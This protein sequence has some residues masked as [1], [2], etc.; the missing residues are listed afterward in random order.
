MHLSTEQHELLECYKQMLLSWNAIH[1]LSGAKDSQSIQKNIDNSLFPLK[2]IDLSQKHLI[3]DIGSGNGFPA[4]PLHIALRIPTILCEPN[5]KK[6]AFLQNIKATLGLQNLSIQRKKIESLKLE[7]LPDC[8]TSR[9]T[10]NVAI[11]LEKCKHCIKNETTILLYKGSNVD[12]E[13]PKG[14]KHTRFAHAL[15]QYLVINGKEV[16]C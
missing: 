16:L 10:F 11:L 7:T 9:A 8:I 1:S 13:I 12:N 3:L 5:A 4:I 14:L 2:K 15:L 6:V